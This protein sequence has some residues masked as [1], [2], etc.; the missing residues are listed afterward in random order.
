MVCPGRNPR[1]LATTR[2][3]LLLG[4]S[5]GGPFEVTEEVSKTPAGIVKGAAVAPVNVTVAVVEPAAVVVTKPYAE[6][7]PVSI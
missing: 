5:T 6:L 3:K 2:E 4:V 1:V 7:S